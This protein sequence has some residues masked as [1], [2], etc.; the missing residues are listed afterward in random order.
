VTLQK[1]QRN[2]PC[3]CGSGKKYKK[4]CLDINVYGNHYSE[5]NLNFL[6]LEEPNS[7]K[8]SEVIL[9][10]IGEF[11]SEDLTDVEEKSIILLAIGA[12][13]FSFLEKD[14]LDKLLETF[15]QSLEEDVRDEMLFILRQL[16]KRKQLEY[17]HINLYILVFNVTKTKNGS[18]LTI[19]S[20]FPPK[21]RNQILNP[22][23]SGKY[24]SK[25]GSSG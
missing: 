11:L 15:P 10:Y 25:L 3:P 6:K 8:M 17:P 22:L 16:I 9:E 14:E 7:L 20:T 23:Y 19:V 21:E 13:N 1:I 12:W 24:F 2:D 4:C 18:V 5:K